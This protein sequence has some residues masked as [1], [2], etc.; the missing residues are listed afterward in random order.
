MITEKTQEQ[1]DLLAR[2]LIL[3]VLRGLVIFASCAGMLALIPVVF[4]GLV[5][6]GLH[7]AMMGD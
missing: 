2:G 4:I 3:S 5:L 1:K 7:S 6:F